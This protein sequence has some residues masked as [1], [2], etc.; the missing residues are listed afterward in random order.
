MDFTSPR[1]NED[2]V[3]CLSLSFVPL[4]VISWI[5]FLPTEGDPRNHTKRHYPSNAANR[6]S[7]I[8]PPLRMPTT[9]LPR[10]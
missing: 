7:G 1:I 4:C 6:S 8:F 3:R 2:L 5:E 9:F 10:S